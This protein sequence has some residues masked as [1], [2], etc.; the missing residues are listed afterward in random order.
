LPHE[1]DA[2]DKTQQQAKYGGTMQNRY[3]Q[4]KTR[5]E[6]T[7]IA[8]NVEA[9]GEQHRVLVRTDLTIRELREELVNKLFHE[10]GN[11]SDYSVMWNGRALTLSQP[12]GKQ[13][14]PSGAQIQVV[15]V[16]H[17][18]AVEGVRLYLVVDPDTRF[19]L[20]RL[21]ALIGRSAQPTQE[22]A[23]NLKDV[24]NGASVSRKHAEISRQG[25]TYLIRNHSNSQP[26]YVT[27]PGEDTE[28]SLEGDVTKEIVPGSVIRL[29]KVTFTFYIQASADSVN[30][31]TQ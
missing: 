14:I 6:K 28:V 16:K 3:T 20:T 24:P 8:L 13:G 31:G 10:S 21:P 2:P 30:E 11:R 12:I 17:E 25:E 29:G 27:D 23:V 26:V 15:R 7:H 5:L 22:L 4:L 1:P 18:K 9:Q 19:E